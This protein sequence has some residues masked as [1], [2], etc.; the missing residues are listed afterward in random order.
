[1]SSP[2][3]YF[4]DEFLSS[5]ELSAARLDGHLVE[6]GEAYMP[7]D[8]V[9]TPRLRAL[10]LRSFARPGLALTHGSAAWVHGVR[11]DPPSP[12]SLQRVGDRRSVY[13]LDSRI[14]FRDGRMPPEDTVDLAGVAVTTLA[15]TL[16]DLLR[17][18]A[19][20]SAFPGPD[21]LALISRHPEA[22][23]PA[24]RLLREAGPVTFKRPAIAW[25]ARHRRRG[26][27]DVT[28]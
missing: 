15:R 21:A 26:Q 6:I 7:A 2:Y 9:E 4:A 3:L 25:L 16:G 19:A 12:H 23:E 13:P 11:A 20:T 28:R 22:V 8:A 5:A 17:A 10:S 24:L 1:M 27:D 14:R 18:D